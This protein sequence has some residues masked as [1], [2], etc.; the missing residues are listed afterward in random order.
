VSSA[1]GCTS[2]GTKT[3]EVWNRPYG[4]FVYSKTCL[5]KT[6]TLTAI[7]S[8]TGALV[9]SYQ[10]D[11]NNSPLSVEASGA[12]VTHTFAAAGQ[13]TLNLLLTSDKGCKNIVPGNVYINYNPQPN[14]FAPKRMGCT[15]LCITIQD[16]TAALTGPAKNVSWEWDFGN[17]QT[18]T[19]SSGASNSTCYRNSSYYS[20]MK[21]DVKLTVKS[22]SG[23]VDSIRRKNYVVVYPK[24][25]ADFSWSPEDGD[26]LTPIISFTNTSEGFTNFQWY[27]NDAPN[28]LDSTHNSVK[29][30]FKTDEPITVNIYL[31]IRNSYGCKDT[32]MKPVDIGPN[33]TFY[34]PN[35]F[36][37]NGDGVNDL[38]TGTG[39]GI[40]KFKMWIYD[41]WGE[42]VYYTDDITKGW[43]GSIKGKLIESKMDV[44]QWKVIVTDLLGKDHPYVGHVTQ[45]R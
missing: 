7:P 12:Q 10:W 37:P 5:T 24:P 45:L 26:V 20:P 11:Y 9:A 30:Y 40:K 35:T 41:R 44:Y 29:H 36:T 39:V 8:P 28:A 34:I 38:F 43:D 25:R 17:G 22:D 21:Y 27:F 6:T 23:C 1:N 15:D 2:T 31:A 16:S 18:M 4:S 32:V 19:A 42:M 3:V 13:Q 14:L 33:F